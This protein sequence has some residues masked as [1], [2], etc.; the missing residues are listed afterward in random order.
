M[1]G[2]ENLCD[3]LAN[4]DAGSHMNFPPA[5]FTVDLEIFTWSGLKMRG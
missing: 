4:D 2:A 1:F 5:S 3:A